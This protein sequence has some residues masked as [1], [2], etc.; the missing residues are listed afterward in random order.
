M[1]RQDR[2]PADPSRTHERREDPRAIPG[3]S[4]SLRFVRSSRRLRSVEGPE[5]SEGRAPVSPHGAGPLDSREVVE[6][7]ADA[8]PGISEQ[9][10][11]RSNVDGPTDLA[12]EAA[13]LGTSFDG[14]GTLALRDHTANTLAGRTPSS[15][16]VRRPA[17]GSTRASTDRSFRRH[18][19]RAVP[20]RSQA[21]TA[22]ALVGRA[23]ALECPPRWQQRRTRAPL[24][25]PDRG[26][27]GLPCTRLRTRGDG[28][29]THGPWMRI[30]WV[31]QS[32][33][34]KR[35]AETG[36]RHP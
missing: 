14:A 8:A 15:H 5:L 26:T 3:A 10:G 23:F 29:L 20:I 24:G 36:G 2:P 34:G 19:P 32:G 6:P 27:V 33:G 17:H 25:E 7:L 35:E 1:P 28:L 22:Q 12:T 4:R 11:L 21:P 30:Q 13:W 9:V 16:S 18:P 31:N